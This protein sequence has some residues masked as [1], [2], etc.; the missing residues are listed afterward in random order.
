[1]RFW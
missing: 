1:M